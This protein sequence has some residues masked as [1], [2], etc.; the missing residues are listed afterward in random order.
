MFNNWSSP[1][2]TNCMFTVNS[3]EGGGGGMYNLFYDNANI[4][5][6]TF[7]GNSASYGGGMFNDHSNPTLTNCIFW[8]DIAPTGAEIYNDSDSSAN[9][10]YSDVEGGWPGG[11][12]I[13][14]DPLF[15]DADLRLPA[16]SPCIDV[17]DN[18]AVPGWVVTDLDGNPRIIGLA[19][20]MGAFE[21]PLADPVQL[22]ERLAQQVIDLNLQSGIE[23]SLDA[24]LD[25]ALKAIDDINENNNVAAINTLQ[26]FINAV[27]AQRGNK[28]PEVDA[29]DLI[30]DVLDI[31]EL[32]STG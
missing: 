2:I 11:G 21:A 17:G 14:A 30:A 32:L 19:V 12:N 3:A 9:V 7:S 10:S 15:A 8:T 25:A 6:C 20:D 5:N 29:D 26:G 28:I 27:E 31:I 13:D 23:N 4:T 1:T 24:K 16:E 22:L 18:S